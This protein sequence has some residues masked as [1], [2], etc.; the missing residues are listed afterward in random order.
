MILN[1][2]QPIHFNDLVFSIAKS[3]D[4]WGRVHAIEHL[5][6]TDDEI[7]RWLLEHGCD[8]G[9]LDMYVALNCAVKGDLISALKQK[10]LDDNL[11]IGITRVFEGLLEADIN[12][13]G[14]INAYEHGKEAL[15]LYVQHAKSRPDH[16]SDRVTDLLLALSVKEMQEY[17]QGES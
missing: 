2:E 17:E 16:I 1:P 4:G 12:I 13:G 14:G 3:V 11:F 6:P 15:S 7:K 9:V 5:E 10:T 8:G